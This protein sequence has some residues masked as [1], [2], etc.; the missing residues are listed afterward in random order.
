MR[1][2]CCEPMSDVRMGQQNGICIL[3]LVRVQLS[4]TAR[5]S[6]TPPVKPPRMDRHDQNEVANF[7]QNRKSL[8]RTCVSSAKLIVLD[9]ETKDG[10]LLSL[11]RASVFGGSAG[12]WTPSK[13]TR[14][15]LNCAHNHSHRTT[16]TEIGSSD[17]TSAL[18]GGTGRGKFT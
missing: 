1:R 16:R 17:S 18:A 14:A 11:R 4:R 7:S 9:D 3:G 10:M 8:R 13:S 6:R 12:N 2:P 5:P 15:H